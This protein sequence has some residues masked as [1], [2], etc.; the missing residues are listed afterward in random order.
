MRVVRK[1][2]P[3]GT[4]ATVA[5]EPYG[6]SWVAVDGA[7]DL[8]IGGGHFVFRV[9]TNGVSTTLACSDGIPTCQ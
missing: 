8:Y 6:V 5:L 4:I 2:S 3:N 1:V 7:G 9:D